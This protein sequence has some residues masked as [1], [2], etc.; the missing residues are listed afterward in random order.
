M[1]KWEC[2]GFQELNIYDKRLKKEFKN[3]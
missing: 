2:F 1:V 3:A